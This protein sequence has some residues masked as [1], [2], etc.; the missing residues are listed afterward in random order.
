MACAAVSPIE[1]AC[2]QQRLA[3]RGNPR[4][5]RFVNEFGDVQRR[6]VRGDVETSARANEHALDV[7]VP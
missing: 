1:T 6:E 5:G 4:A 3:M 2:P 7:F